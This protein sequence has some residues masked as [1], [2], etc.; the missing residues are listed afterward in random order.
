MAHIAGGQVD[1]AI[2]QQTRVF[3]T[4]ADPMERLNH[5]A[6][7]DGSV[8]AGARYVLVDDVTTMGGTLAELAHY[9]QANNGTAAG[10]VVLVNAAR[11][12]RLIPDRHM[13]ALLETRHGDVIREVFQIDPAALTAEEAQYLVGFRSADEIRN[14]SLAAKQETHRRLRAKGIDRLGGETG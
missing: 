13:T 11:S 1:R 6:Q 14:R 10:V 9:I 12:G 7:F 4:G 8:Q 5:R 2:V 3:H